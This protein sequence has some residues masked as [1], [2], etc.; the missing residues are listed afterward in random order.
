MAEAVPPL[1]ETETADY[2][3][4]F[5]AGLLNP[6]RALPSAL[7]AI[8]K[9]TKRYGVYRNNVVVGLAEALGDAYPVTKQLLGEKMF[10]SLACEYVRAHPPQNAVM[11]HYGQDF[12]RWLSLNKRLE[13]YRYVVDIAQIEAFRIQSY[14]AADAVML[15]L[16]TI[17]HVDKYRLE[18]MRVLLHPSVHIFSSSYP[19][20]SIWRNE[21]LGE[22]NPVNLDQSEAVLIQRPGWSVDTNQ[23]SSENQIFLNFLQKGI[24]FG[25]VAE[26]MLEHYPDYDLGQALVF[27]FSNKLVT[28]IHFETDAENTIGGAK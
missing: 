18:Y 20:V 17:Q 16:E 9:Q 4:D 7:G 22:Q 2:Q 28:E 14:H 19:V 27:L 15:G 8:K 24:P 25:E 23:L 12:P 11:L 10:F 21:A 1:A 3:S 5:A 26:N 13:T 6:D